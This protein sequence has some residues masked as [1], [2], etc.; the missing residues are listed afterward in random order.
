M[1]CCCKL[2][3]ARLTC[4]KFAQPICQNVKQK[5]E[6]ERKSSLNY[7]VSQDICSSVAVVKNIVLDCYPPLPFLK[8]AVVERAT[9]LL[10]LLNRQLLST[11]VSCVIW[12]AVVSCLYNFTEG[13]FFNDYYCSNMQQTRQQLSTTGFCIFFLYTSCVL[14]CLISCTEPVT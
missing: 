2:L 13:I 14:K 1:V 4:L 10:S 5:I 11:D 3:F 6:R 8:S 9:F 12:K 7:I